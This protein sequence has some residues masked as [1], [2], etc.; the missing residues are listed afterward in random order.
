MVVKYF[1]HVQVCLLFFRLVTNA[2]AKITTSKS[3]ATST[4]AG[5]PIKAKKFKLKFSFT[6][7]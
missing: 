6:L 3:H 2:P 5:T 4:K 7:R 1:Y